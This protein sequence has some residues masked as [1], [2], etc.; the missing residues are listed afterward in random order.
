MI[1]YT[2]CFTVDTTTFHHSNTSI[3]YTSHFQQSHLL[4]LPLNATAIMARS[5]LVAIHFILLFAGSACGFS[6]DCLGRHVRLP[7]SAAKDDID[8]GSL[9]GGAG[10]WRSKAKEFQENP[11]RS[12]GGKRLNIAFVVSGYP[13]NVT[14]LTISRVQ[15]NPGNE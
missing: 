5:C 11:P 6:S 13:K 12:F 9:S 10:S 4:P 15:H 14:Q 3:K 2:A 1:A 8:V 7:L